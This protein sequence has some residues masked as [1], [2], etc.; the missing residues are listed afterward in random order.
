MRKYP[1]YLNLNK[2]EL[3]ERIKQA[4][5]I[6]A[7]C[8]ICPRQCG[9]NRLEN[10][11]ARPLKLRSGKTKQGFCRLG[12]KAMVSSWHS[13]FGEEDC[14]V[15]RFG[16]GTIFFTHCNLA[17]VYCQN[18]EISQ[19]GEG[20]KVSSEKLVEM[21]LNLQ[22]LGCHNINFV[23]PTPQVPQILAALPLA[24]EKGLS[25]PL[26]YNSN[27]YDSVKTLKLLNGIIDIYMPDVKY[28]DDEVAIKYSAVP[29]STRYS[30]SK[31]NRMGYF[32][33][34]RDTVKE[35][36]R[37]V[38]DLQ[39]NQDGL[40]VRGLL[41]RHLVLPVGLAGTQKIME[42]LAKEIS[43]NTFVNIMDQYRPCWKALQYPPLDRL[44]SFEEYYQ[45]RDLAK[46]AGLKRTY[47]FN[48]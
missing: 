33:I 8:E 36:H 37:Q 12:K 16:S 1:A 14:L 11:E 19:V 6:L 13:H 43:P 32:E 18:Y 25:V 35:M 45:A 42:F 26:V 5:A 34:M 23:T 3:Q 17:C 9:V 15:G 29:C 27:A 4:F 24:I 2:S 38:G 31:S 22:K 10:E 46:K 28:A 44:I 39:V 41:I 30:L 7:K 40:A 47:P 21:I 48:W 20:K